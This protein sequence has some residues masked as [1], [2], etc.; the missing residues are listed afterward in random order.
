[1]CSVCSAE[2]ELPEKIKKAKERCEK[3]TLALVM[4]MKAKEAKIKAV[5]RKA[6][7][8]ELKLAKKNENADLIATLEQEI[9]DVFK[10]DAAADLFGEVLVEEAEVRAGITKVKPSKT[11]IRCFS[12]W[13]G[14][15]IDKF[16][17]IKKVNDAVVDP[18]TNTATFTFAQLREICGRPDG[19]LYV[20]FKMGKREMFYTDQRRASTKFRSSNTGDPDAF[21]IDNSVSLD[22]QVVI[23]NELALQVYLKLVQDNKEV[24]NKK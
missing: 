9:E 5:Y 2:T 3:A 13:T 23:N 7:E 22:E 17:L 14:T 20:N 16:A 10:A 15:E 4:D 21:S 19:T 12:V 1:M 6:L 24:V 11:P 8:R 18:K